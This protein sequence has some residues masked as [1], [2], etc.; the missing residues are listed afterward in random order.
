MGLK[1]FLLIP[2][3]AFAF[4][5]TG[6]NETTSPSTTPYTLSLAMARTS[7]TALG[8]FRVTVTLEDS[9][10]RLSGQT[11]AV[12]VDRG[13]AGAVTDN[14]D[15]TYSF[16]VTPSATGT[17][18]VTVS[19]GGA[20][21]VRKA[22]V[23]DAY[24]AG[25]GQ[26]MAIP[27]DYVNT[28]GY[29]DGVTITPDGEYLF[30]QYGPIHMSGVLSFSS[31]CS[32]G[33]YSGGYDLNTCAGRT[34]S[35]LVFDTVGPMAAPQR[36]DFPLGGISNGKLLHLPNV[37][38]AG[39]YNGIV[40]FPTA[41]YGFKRQAD[42]TFAEPFKVAFNDERGLNGPFG[43]SFKPNGDG[44]ATF[45]VAWNNYFNDLGDDGADVY[46]GTL[47]FGQAKNLGDVTY[48]GGIYSA[49]S[50]N[51]TPV[52]FSSHTGVQGNP[53]LYYDTS[54]TVKSIWTDDEVTAHDLSVYR[55][56]AG[57]FPSGTWT[58]D[59]LPSVI[60]TAG[61]ENQPFFTGDALIFRRASSI[62]SH[63]YRPT[64][65]A[66]GSTYT[67]NDC[68]GPEVV[69]LGSNGHTGVGEIFTV[70]EPTIATREGK[71]YLYFVYIES[72]ENPNVA[73]TY[74]WNAQAASV[75]IP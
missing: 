64:N 45:I 46:T 28:S 55:L 66:C 32:S 43:L 70:G 23:L 13:T 35:S 6:K 10:Q 39:V 56:T 57:T 52:S 42:G 40:G 1:N 38:L 33:S 44:T 11:L 41:F 65:G 34:N 73:G 71:R 14:G 20:S 63:A 9:G 69:L 19:F 72:R 24:V 36:P 59:T 25:S 67:H 3:A 5:C 47:T 12:T 51:I 15:G 62:V 75:E 60:N 58:K 54:G 50:P 16:T 30:V 4:A 53:H 22:V 37:V 31:I 74:D 8:P 27:G 68:W 2:V 17:H 48:S 61:D 26:P 49:I 29:E 21:I 7:E 18:T